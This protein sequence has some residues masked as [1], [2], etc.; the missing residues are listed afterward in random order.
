LDDIVIFGC[1][2]YFSPKSDFLGFVD[3]RY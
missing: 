2:H 1:S 3:L